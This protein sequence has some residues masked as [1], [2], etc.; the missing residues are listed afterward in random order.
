[1][2]ALLS[3]SCLLA[4]ALRVFAGEQAVAR[5][6]ASTVAPTS[7]PRPMRLFSRPVPTPHRQNIAVGDVSFTAQLT[8][9]SYR[10]GTPVRIRFILSN[11]SRKD[12]TLITGPGPTPI[13]QLSL[14]NSAGISLRPD[15]RIILGYPESVVPAM[16]LKPGAA[17]ATQ[18][19]P[20]SDWGYRPMATGLYT[21]SSH[22][23][24][25]T[26]SAL[27]PEATYSLAASTTRISCFR[28]VSR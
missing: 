19:Y 25:L 27:R 17:E 3:V 28:I 6:S 23:A 13:A 18:W 4:I 8:A 20:L 15:R 2:A 16:V 24:F 9:D 14:S 21:I 5:M 26:M 11:R 7:T 10:S 1:M 12:I 22:P